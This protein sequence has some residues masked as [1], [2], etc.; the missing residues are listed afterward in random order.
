MEPQICPPT[1]TNYFMESFWVI[2]ILVGIALLIIA[3]YAL[4]YFVRRLRRSSLSKH[5]LWRDKIEKIIY[6][7]IKCIFWVFG[8]V[9]VLNI[10]GLRFGF[11]SGMTY[12]MPFRN[13]AIVICLAWLLMRWKKEF[14]LT[15]KLIDPGMS[16]ILGRLASFTIILLTVLLVLQ[17]LGLNIMPLIAFGGVG[18]AALGFAAK[19]VIANFCGGLMLHITRPFTLGDL[20]ILPDR[21]IEGHVENIGWYFTS[22]RDKDKRPVYL[23][24]AF[25]S[26]LMVVNAS[27]MSHRH[28]L[29]TLSIR[30]EDI[31]KAPQIAEAIKSYLT[32][33]PAIDHNLP[34]IVTL[35]AFKDYSLHIK[36]DTYTLTTRLDE[37]YSLKQ[38]ILLHV[39]SIITQHGAEM[40]YP[41][42]VYYQK[43]L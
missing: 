42:A 4:K 2:E 39:Y 28:F 30:Y 3:N 8:I 9:Y 18:A 43:N 33:H 35:D 38:E 16:H 41:T 23:P 6:L 15:H 24:N 32:A 36:I 37:F 26:T 13:A 31:D 14:Q 34:T 29:E 20:I 40:P 12:L 21:Q 5:A 27:R 1:E 22:I 25:F 7:P 11:I 19:D 10:L 17:I